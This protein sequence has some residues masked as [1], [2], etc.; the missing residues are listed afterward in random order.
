MVEP[1]EL[2]TVCVPVYNGA[3]FVEETLSSIRKQSYQSFR[4]VISVDGSTDD[5]ASICRTFLDD[6]RFQIFEQERRLGWVGNCNWLLSHVTTRYFCIIPHDDILDPSYIER[7]V[8]TSEAHP[9]AAVVY[10]DIRTFGSIGDQIIIQ[11]SIYGVRLTRV[12]A[13]LVEHFNAVAFRGLVRLETL[14]NAGRLQNNPCDD[15]AADTIWLMKLV[16]QGDFVR[17]AEP[18]YAKRYH[19]ASVHR[20]WSTWSREQNLLAWSHHCLELAVEAFKG[21]LTENQQAIIL[22][23]LVFRLLSISPFEN[24]GGLLKEEQQTVISSFLT[25]LAETVKED[26]L[27]P[28]QEQLRQLA[29]VFDIRRD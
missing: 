25:R 26:Q 18:L 29:S 28:A 17:V 21:D 3:A 12:L 8:A 19:D 6:H 11:N 2:V 15:F 20:E 1:R 22:H 4:V 5:S 7:L 10:S 16:M 9:G 13:F 23:A 27:N 14:K 24:I